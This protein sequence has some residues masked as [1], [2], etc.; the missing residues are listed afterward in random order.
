MIAD[1]EETVCAVGKHILENV[2]FDVLIAE[3]GKKAVDVFCENADDIVCVL[4]DLSMPGLDGE[5]VFQE[6]KKV[7]PNVKVILSSGYNEQDVTQKFA[8]KGLAGFIQKPY[9]PQTLLEKI[10][11]IL[12]DNFVSIY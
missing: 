1:D 6:I 3:D 10:K 4:L 9:V 11:E 5:E 8:G 2:G 12:D 7:K